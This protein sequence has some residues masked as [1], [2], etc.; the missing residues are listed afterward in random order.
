MTVT[1]RTVSEQ[2]DPAAPGRWW[3][4]LLPAEQLTRRAVVAAAIAAMAM[5]SV[6]ALLVPAF[7]PIDELAN[8]GYARLL[9]AGDLPTIDTPAPNDGIPGLEGRLFYERR[10]GNTQRFDAWTA[11]H[12]PLAYALAGV[13]LALGI[14]VGQPNLGMLVARL[15]SVAATGLAVVAVALLTDALLPRPV[16]AGASRAARRHAAVIGAA[17]LTALLPGLVHVGGLVYN[18]ALAFALGTLTL[19]GGI[20]VLRDG[21]DRFWPVLTAVAGAAAALTRIATLPA[22]A[23]AA[24]ACAVGAWLAAPAGRDHPVQPKVRAAGNHLA[25]VLVCAVGASAWF[26]ARNVALYGDVTGSAALFA[27]FGR[28][29]DL[30][31]GGEMTAAGLAL[32]QWDRLL[33]D[34]TA[35]YWAYGWRVW[36]GRGLLTMLVLGI[37]VALLRLA[38]R[39]GEPTVPWRLAAGWG[40]GVLL[41][42]ATVVSNA[43]FHEAGGSPHGR[44]LLVAWGV[45]AAAGGCGM[46]ALPGS[47]RGIP[48]WLAVLALTACNAGLLA[49]LVTAVHGPFTLDGVAYELPRLA[50]A[51]GTVAICAL[52]TIWGGGVGLAM[53]ALRKGAR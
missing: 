48:Q 8:V 6:H 21:P 44:Y 23:L 35:G 26:Y 46:A 13:P 25:L 11:N 33:G 40:V 9:L 19:A 20:R 15:V 18:D 27:K 4:R 12:P 38:L 36:V 29:A 1:E 53:S 30:P 52:L 10:A 39:R 43:Q 3:L 16:D 47:R 37:G 14:A 50:G 7:W 51:A 17:L 41:V 28:S 5:A 24:L 31:I 22:V 2:R 45:L 42:V 34:L 32:D 49:I